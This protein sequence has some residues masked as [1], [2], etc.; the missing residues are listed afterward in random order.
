MMLCVRDKVLA[1]VAMLAFTTCLAYPFPTYAQGPGLKALILMPGPLI[2]DHAPEENN[3][4]VCH[5]SFDKTA[6][7]GLCLDCHEEVAVDRASNSGFHGR[8]Q[9]ARDNSC[10][11]CHKDHMGRDFDSVP[12]D[13][14]T[15]DHRQT[16]F[17]LSGAH[18]ETNCGA[19]HTP[20][21]AL[22]EAPTACIE[23]HETDNPHEQ[24]MGQQCENCH[25][26]E[27][28]LVANQFDHDSTEFALQGR[29]G[30]VACA[31]CH[32]GERYSFETSTCVSCHRVRDV[33]L[34]SFGEQCDSCHGQQDWTEASFDHDEQTD[35]KLRGAHAQQ[36]CTACHHNN[37]PDQ[38]PPTRCVA[39]HEAA[40]VH[41]GRHGDD[42]QTCHDARQ[43]QTS[44]F[45]HGRD[46]GWPLPAEHAQL[47]CQQ[48]HRGSLAE[49][50]E[51]QCAGCHSGDNVH[52]SKQMTGCALCHD[53]ADWS[54]AD[55]FNHELATF[56]LEGMHA[57]ATCKTCHSGY[58]FSEAKS[59]CAECHSA[60][61]K[62]RGALGEACADCHSPNGWT[63]W[64]FDHKQQTDFELG[65]AHSDLECV[66]CH[67]KEDEMAPAACG[68]CHAGDDRHAGEFGEQ[69]DDCHNTDT[70]GEVRWPR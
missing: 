43:W 5:S 9:D 22:R 38:P 40:D 47:T 45:D 69:C 66:S 19:C 41:S 29:H 46:G 44:A 12:L 27:D 35:F 34:G 59:A 56:P 10:N 11:S 20:D 8:S 57:V 53:P 42:C 4:E 51:R 58:R 25:E 32:A 65:G 1:L 23:C 21:Q 3:C 49:P 54:G 37:S 30:E 64:L 2:A 14:D 55:G 7:D 68:S 60:D 70:F 26:P 16:D 50:L 48:C 62:H 33:H 17:A 67:S 18:R 63:L 24:A 52:R 31:A 13:R 28:W 15:F 6:Q 61:D 39:C 36:P